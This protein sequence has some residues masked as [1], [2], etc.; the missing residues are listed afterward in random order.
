MASRQKILIAGGV[1]F[2]AGTAAV[3]TIYLPFYSAEAAK[4][5]EEM[6]AKGRG[7]LASAG[8]GTRGSMWGNMGKEIKKHDDDS[9][10]KS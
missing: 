8:G 2:L 10:S 5:R 9:H 3:V 7:S 6:N 4:R 1:T